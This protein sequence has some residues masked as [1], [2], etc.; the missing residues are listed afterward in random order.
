MPVQI[1]SLGA[2]LMTALFFMAVLN[3]A[4]DRA[5]AQVN[6]NLG[7][8]TASTQVLRRGALF[9]PLRR[10]LVEATATWRLV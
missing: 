10:C 5:I 3:V 7:I 4:L 1:I 6:Q 2:A 9:K 8:F